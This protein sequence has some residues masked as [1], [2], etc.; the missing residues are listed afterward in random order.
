MHDAYL[1]GWNLLTKLTLLF[2]SPKKATWEQKK[3]AIVERWPLWEGRG[4]L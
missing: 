1:Q 2:T 3:V 4:V